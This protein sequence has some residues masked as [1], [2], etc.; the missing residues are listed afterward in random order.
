M[1]TGRSSLVCWLGRS[2]AHRPAVIV[3]VVVVVAAA[4]V[5]VGVGKT[6]Y[7]FEDEHGSGSDKKA[8]E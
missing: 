7:R 3:M 8:A 2:L 5:A 1:G 4:V 6:W